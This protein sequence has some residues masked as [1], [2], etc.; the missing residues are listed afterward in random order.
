MSSK[1]QR[2]GRQQSL[3]VYTNYVASQSAK[4]CGLYGN[5]TSLKYFFGSRINY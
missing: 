1:V 5:M 4:E 3:P 2:F